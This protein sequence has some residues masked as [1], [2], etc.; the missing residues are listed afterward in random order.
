MTDNNKPARRLASF[1]KQLLIISWKNA[2]LFKQRKAGLIC[3][4]I[5]SCLFMGVFLLMIYFSGPSL[6][7]P[8]PATNETILFTRYLSSTDKFYYYPNNP[9]V[10]SLAKRALQKLVSTSGSPDVDQYLIGVDSPSVED[11]D[12]E[13]KSTVFAMVYLLFHI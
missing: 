9:F 13:F 3:E 2:L 8:R 12:R 7:K 11:F 10:R 5:F 6:I 4:I 1:P